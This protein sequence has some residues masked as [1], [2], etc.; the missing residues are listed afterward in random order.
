MN[1]PPAPDSPLRRIML[2]EARRAR[3]SVQA[4]ILLSD[5][6]SA[7]YI[8]AGRV[9]LF[10]VPIRHGQ[11][12]GLRRHLGELG[13]GEVFFGVPH[14]AVGS[15]VGVLA[16]ADAD[17][18]LRRVE[19]A[20][21]G[22]LA[23]GDDFRAE[24]RAHVDRWVNLMSHALGGSPAPSGSARLRAG[25]IFELSAGGSARGGGEVVWIPKSPTLA[26]QGVHR[27]VGPDTPLFPIGARGWFRAD[28]AVV[29]PAWS[30][31]DYLER[32]HTLSA[33]EPFHRT[34]R[35]ALE[36]RARADEL[37]ERERIQLKEDADDE[38][39]REMMAAL[40]DVVDAPPPPVEHRD[41]VAAALLQIARSLGMEQA[42]TLAAV[43]GPP[44][45]RV[46][47][48]A[49][50]L[51]LRTRRVLL[52]DRWWTRDN[53]PLLA[54]V[55]PQRRPV[56]LLRKGGR[57]HVYDPQARR[58]SALSPEAVERL[59]PF[60]Y[61]FF[62]TLPG[63]SLGRRDLLEFAFFGIRRDL[64]VALSL[65]AIVGLFGIAFP[66]VTGQIFDSVIPGAER[67]LLVQIVLLLVSLAIGS[68][69]LTLVR[70]VAMLRVETTMSTGVQAATW[71]R[72]LNLPV[73][74]FRDYTAGDLAERATGID[75]IHRA[76]SGS[77]VSSMFSAIFATWYLLLLFYYDLRLAFVAMGLLVV[78]LS[79]SVGSS[80]LQL[81]YQRRIAALRGRIL[82]ILLQVFDG[83][84]KIRVAGLERAAFYLWA[85]EFRTL[86]MIRYR[87]TLVDIWVGGVRQ[88]Y[89]A[90]T[91]SAIFYFAATGPAQ[92][93]S[94]GQF[95]A[96]FAAFTIFMGS[97]LQLLESGLVL[98]STIPQW[99]RVRPILDAEV[100]A[101]PHKEHPG[102]LTGDIEVTQLSFRY[103]PDQP[104]V[105]DQVNLRIEAGEFVAVVGASG[106]GKST[107]LRLL[108]GFEQPATGTVFY[109][110]Q[111]LSGLDVPEVRRQLGVVLQDSRVLSGSIRDNICG[112]YV[113]DDD[114]VWRALRRAGL[115][116][117]VEAMPM[118][119]HTIVSHG[120]T[121]LSGGQRQRLMIARAIV[122][123]PKI[124]LFD[125]AT[126]ALDNRTQ[127][128]V[129][130]S[131]EALQV[132]RVVIAH[133]LSTIQNVDR[134]LV[135][136]KGRIVDEGT[137]EELLERE[138]PF[139]Q[140]ALRQLT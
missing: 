83:I 7:W 74:F 118:G 8:E 104:M 21:L 138:G 134:I 140:L 123:E 31:A 20:R 92:G 113:L 78:P 12:V 72:L 44:H 76:L 105:I 50:A 91:T 128:V 111:P 27:V 42:P 58:T 115:A 68:T 33:L 24:V 60:G 131:L 69:V 124:L 43:E 57:Y 90:I 107:L 10:W 127:A 11:P 121:S 46:R 110:G 52:E 61:S 88:F 79:L 130:E 81:R 15:S 80:L 116:D 18:R 135:M 96:F 106:C 51:R 117:D 64:T 120:G 98:V 137:Y 54:F 66:L 37:A 114:Q 97:L 129:S 32:D 29:A 77:V 125:E 70:S 56:A 119:L 5:H 108:L 9:D 53:G 75:R 112:A 86:R 19:V 93:L 100:E 94:T 102:R 71:D 62:R 122:N 35:R 101:D 109:S 2:S 139:V 99:E 87:S 40:V 13:P 22:E 30:T 6:G 48:L 34:V 45:D 82:G 89:P 67:G 95:L 47:H 63:T 41:P 84:A 3:V 59:A 85:R 73:E 136:D 16:V 23:R 132:T 26:I 1:A 55:G 49:R 38:Q 28:E 25:Q 4:P 133:R 17:A 39:L 103:T 14:E 36:A 126:S 65:G